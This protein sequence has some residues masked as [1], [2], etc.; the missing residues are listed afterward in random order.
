[1]LGDET[2]TVDTV[3]VARRWSGDYLLLWRVPPGY[4]GEL[5]RGSRGRA[6]AWL[7]KH[8]ALAQGRAA[9]AGGNRIYDEE[10]MKQ[11]KAFQSAAGMAPDGVAGPRTILRLCNASPDNR[12]PV[13]KA[14]RSEKGIK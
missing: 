2:R 3:E 8:L 1:M 6:A 12:D 5:K 9:P 10:M 11:V 13:L 7:G 14:V 4:E